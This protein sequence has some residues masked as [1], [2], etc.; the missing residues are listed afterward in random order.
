MTVLKRDDADP[1]PD[2]TAWQAEY[3]SGRARPGR[4][5]LDLG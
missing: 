5:G 1:K 4:P 2:T 3:Y